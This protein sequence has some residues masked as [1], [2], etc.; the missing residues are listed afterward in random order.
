MQ[1]P[2]LGRLEG[3]VQIQVARLRMYLADDI[4]VDSA[5]TRPTPLPRESM[6]P[7]VAKPLTM[8]AFVMVPPLPRA[9]APQPR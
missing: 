8:V 7:A 2:I 1:Q 4:V 9:F 5:I 6:V 3:R